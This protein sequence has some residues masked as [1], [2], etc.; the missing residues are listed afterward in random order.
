MPRKAKKVEVDHKA[1]IVKNL[2]IMMEY[3]EINKEPYKVKAYKN[4][5]NSLLGL[6]KIDSVETVKGLPGIGKKIEDK[7]DEYFR[8][9]KIT[10]VERVLHDDKYIL[11]N[12]LMNIY[13]VGPAKIAELSKKIEKFE[14][15]YLEKNKGL[16]N[17]KQQIGL[18]YYDALL[19]RIPYKEASQHNK[20]IG[21]VLKKISKD[22]DYCMVGSFRR[23]SKTV[24]DVDILIKNNAKL[25]LKDFI[26]MLEDD[27]YILETLASGA[28]KFMGICKI[29]DNSARRIDILVANDSYYFFAMLYFTGSYTFNIMMRNKALEKGLSL[30]EYGF[31]HKETNVDAVEINEKIKSEE[32][33]FKVLDMEYVEPKKRL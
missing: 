28:N 1:E 16:L 7:I 19:E 5:I 23:K 6:E 13:G 29:G 8:I 18:K 27:A 9:G 14:D 31:K 25:N 33:I 32:D 21:K 22:I 10:E 12:K 17:D 11:K 24:G 3:E 2:N 20:Y 26:K 4:A 30:S 15:L